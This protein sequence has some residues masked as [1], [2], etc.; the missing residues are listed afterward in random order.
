MTGFLKINWFIYAKSFAMDTFYI[1][2]LHVL[3]FAVSSITMLNCLQSAPHNAQIAGKI[4]ISQKTAHTRKRCKMCK[5]ESH[6]SGYPECNFLSNEEPN[7]I[8][9]PGQDSYFPN[10]YSCGINFFD[11]VHYYYAMCH[12]HV[13][14]FSFSFY[15]S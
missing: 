13:H 11:I 1:A 12:V 8:A 3:I 9:F 4:I 5:S 6:M 7:V 10:F 14:G 15:C 2:Q